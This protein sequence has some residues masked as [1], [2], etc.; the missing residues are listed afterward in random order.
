MAYWSSSTPPAST[1]WAA[2]PPGHLR[3]LGPLS[4]RALQSPPPCYGAGAPVATILSDQRTS[5]L[6]RSS[7]FCGLGRQA[8]QRAAATA[9][10]TS[11]PTAAEP[12]ATPEPNTRS[13]FA[14]LGIA[15][16]FQVR[17]HDL[18]LASPLPVQSAAVPAILHGQNVA[19]KACTGS[20][21]TMAYLLPVLQLALERRRAAVQA[22]EV[23]VASGRAGGGGASPAA[24]KQAAAAKQQSRTIQ[25][26]IVAP[27]RELCIQI[28]RAAQDLMPDQPHG[29]RLVV[30]LIGGANPKRQAEAL[31]GGGGGGGAGGEGGGGGA[32][33]VVVV[34]TPGRVAELVDNGTLHVWGCPLLVLD[35]VDEL[36]ALPDFRAAVDSIA[37]HVG[38]R[39]PAKA[40]GSPAPATPDSAGSAPGTAVSGRQTVIVSASLDARALDKY[41]AWC[42]AP[43]P[44]ALTAQQALPGPEAQP[45]TAMPPAH[46]A[47]SR[48]LDREVEHPSDAPAP[49]KEEGRGQLDADGAGGVTVASG[50]A[51]PAAGP[52]ADVLPPHLQ[53]LYVLCPLEHRTDYVRRL[54]HA[55]QCERALLFV[56]KNNQAMVT[57]Y[58]LEARNMQVSILHGELSKLDRG[59]IL[60]AFRRGAFRALVVTDLGARGLD[61]PEC[62]AVICMGPPVDA[63]AYAHRAGRTGRAGASGVVASVVTRGELPR[64]ERMARRLGVTL[65]GVSI[66]N[67]SLAPTEQLAGPQA[68]V[69]R[70]LEGQ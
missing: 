16:P 1:G 60:D 63:M 3:R 67:G 31:A 4:A 41:A 20:G 9:A 24:R 36:L 30:Q 64:L 56:P 33:P 57:K 50:R 51:G 54:I 44:V 21:K 45:R 14:S 59:N 12:L 69:Q 70:H 15:A 48:G 29:R 68:E 22:A 27:S 66:L 55:L 40:L 47:A 13:T 28:Q 53:H 34:G 18:E 52:L 49:S 19:I 39:V 58:R 5:S 62:D 42:P 7:G 32:W 25:A 35:E 8:Q 38:R 65:Q 17:L 43:V 46:E 61:L 23:A 37:A 11:A 10:S 6:T 2:A 26:L